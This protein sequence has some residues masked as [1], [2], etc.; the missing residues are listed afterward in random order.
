MYFVHT[1]SILPSRK[2]AWKKAWPLLVSDARLIVDS[3]G[4]SLSMTFIETTWPGDRECSRREYSR[5]DLGLD[6]SATEFA[7]QAV[8]RKYDVVFSAILLRA[9]QLAGEA[10]YI[11][12]VCAR[13]RIL[14]SALTSVLARLETGKMIG[15]QHRS[16]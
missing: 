11:R 13:P 14:N 8:M 16:W 2:P 6:S 15:I 5:E 9:R 12:Y 7:S 10:I 1:W 4:V 3:A